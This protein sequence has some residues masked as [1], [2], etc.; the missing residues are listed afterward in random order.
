LFRQFTMLMVLLFSL[1]AIN[2]SIA[3]AQSNASGDFAFKIK[4][5]KITQLKQASPEEVF[6]KMVL[7]KCEF[8]LQEI[9]PEIKIDAP[10]V[11][12]KGVG[13]PTVNILFHLKID[14]LNNSDVNLIANKLDLILYADDKPI[15]VDVKEPTATGT[16][17]ETISIPIGKTTT[18][19]A[20]MKVPPD[21]ATKELATKLKGDETY[22]RVDGTFYFQYK[23]LEI[24]ITATMT[25]GTK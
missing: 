3:I 21:K 24:P 14:V 4:K 5:P 15:P 6:R 12:L 13:K 2:S 20:K 10:K 17:T 1:I 16:I 19:P 18:L 7:D 8:T 23:G 11:S 22:Y 25:E 9:K